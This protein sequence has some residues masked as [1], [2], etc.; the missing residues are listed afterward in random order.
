MTEMR[1]WEKMR[2]ERR[3]GQKRLEKFKGIK[4]G[5]VTRREVLSVQ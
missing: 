4:T 5:S 1:S 2:C 3:K